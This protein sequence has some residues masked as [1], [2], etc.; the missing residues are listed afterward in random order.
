MIE[1][2]LLPEELKNRVVKANKPEAILT[3]AGLELKHLILL[4][5]LAFG[6]LLC[7]QL[8]LGLWGI[9]KFSEARILN[10]RWK[11]L[12]SE[13]KAV[14][15]FNNKYA[16]ISEDSQVIQQL[17]RERIIWSEKLNRLSL[18]LPPG[19]WFEELLVNAQGLSLRGAVVS[20]A[21]E[22]MGLIKQ[23]IDNL[24]N[25]PAFSKDFNNL[26]M[27]SAEKKTLGSYDITEFTLNGNL[28]SR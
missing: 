19:V 12:E 13:R 10:G 15:E 21:K 28:K 7:L 9:V 22:E 8:F 16:L 14:E 5:P 26:E 4:I 24:K 6:I 3:T 23:L 20:L 2:N 25:D 11:I 27:G 1:I 17:L 18:D